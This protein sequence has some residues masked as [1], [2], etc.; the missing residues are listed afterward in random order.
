VSKKNL[1]RRVAQRSRNGKKTRH[2]PPRRLVESSPRPT[3]GLSIPGP[4]PCGPHM[5]E[6]RQ[7]EAP[8]T[9]VEVQYQ[10]LAEEHFGMLKKWVSWA[11][12]HLP[13]SSLVE[14]QDLE[15]TASLILFRCVINF[16][17][18]DFSNKFST[19]L[20]RALMNSMGGLVRREAYKQDRAP[21]YSNTVSGWAAAGIDPG[22][23]DRVVFIGFPEQPRRMHHAQ[24]PE[25]PAAG[26][27][28]S[29]ASKT[30]LSSVRKRICKRGAVEPHL[31]K[32]QTAP[33]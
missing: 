14:K 28:I 20:Y 19:Y 4:C 16:D 11:M 8:D 26:G 7:R 15:Q 10:Q 29:P 21:Q 25:K 3:Q 6:D 1:S 12:R 22:N 5:P 23:L 27:A 31:R 13:K 18:E 24:K 33:A 30:H 2:Q 17:P 9:A 32:M